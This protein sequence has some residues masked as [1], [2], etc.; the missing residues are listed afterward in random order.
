[1]GLRGRQLAD[2]RTAE[3]TYAAGRWTA[4]LTAQPATSETV[5]QTAAVPRRPGSHS[6]TKSREV[7]PPRCVSRASYRRRKVTPSPSSDLT[8][9]SGGENRRRWALHDR[10]SVKLP[11]E[12]VATSDAQ[13]LLHSRY[14]RSQA[15]HGLAGSGVRRRQIL[16]LPHDSCPRARLAAVNITRGQNV[17]VDRTF[18]GRVH[19]KLDTQRVTSYRIRMEVMPNDGYAGTARVL[20]ANVVLP[21]LALDARG[22]AVSQLGGQLRRLHYAAPSGPAFD[23]RML[24]ASMP[25][26]GS[27]A[28]AHRGRRCPLLARAFESRA[29]V[30]RFAQPPGTSREKGFAV[31]FYA[32][33]GSRS[34]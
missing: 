25:P 23:G 26:K 28:T 20:R 18:T 13:G 10:A 19:I 27:R 3:H 7:R 9:R 22:V 2:G 8:E 31:C 11:G 33:P 32:R 17:L 4:T 15:R 6:R 34:P 12:Y 5:T 30:P 29:P 16:L 21:R 24:D 14:G 1:M